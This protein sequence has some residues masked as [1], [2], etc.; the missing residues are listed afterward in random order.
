MPSLAARIKAAKAQLAKAEQRLKP[1]REKIRQLTRQMRRKPS[2]QKVAKTGEVVEETVNMKTHTVTRKGET[3]VYAPKDTAVDGK[4][5]TK[6][7]NSFQSAK[8]IIG[9]LRGYSGEEYLRIMLRK[10]MLD[11]LKAQP[12]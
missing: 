2:E 8:I 10:I 5:V 1:I 11:E 9:R 7:Y 6:D 12:A 3:I 4:P